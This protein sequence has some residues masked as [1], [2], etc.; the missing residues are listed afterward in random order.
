[1]SVQQAST[2]RTAS[3]ARSSLIS[4]SDDAIICSVY[5]YHFLTA[6]QVCRLFYDPDSLKFVRSKLKR[7]TDLGYLHRLLLPT[8]SLGKPAFIYTLGRKGI[9]YLRSAGFEDFH[10]FRPS[11][12]EEHSY[13]FLRHTLAVNDFLIAAECLRDSVPGVVLADFAHERDLKKTPVVVKTKADEKVGVIPDAWLDFHLDG[14]LRV[15]VIL[16]LDR[17]TVQQK[18]FARKLRGLLAYS[19]GPYQEFFG[20][21]ALTI[22][23]ACTAGP[24]RCEQMR[25]WCEDVLKET[26]SEQDSEIFL[27]TSLEEDQEWDPKTLFLDPIWHQP[28]SKTPV[29][30]LGV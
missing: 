9:N 26:K 27:F 23:F 17:G 2:I 21:D 29:A 15:S 12:Q 18:P 24:H 6:I 28:F 19:Q 5:R 11:G 3:T 16:E 1:M 14:K 25:R 13:F 4:A 20:S 10:R 22:A 8:V 7:L 30:L